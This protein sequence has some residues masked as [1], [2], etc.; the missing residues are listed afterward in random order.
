MYE[1]TRLVNVVEPGDEQVVAA[2][3]D[4]ISAAATATGART[5]LVSPTLPGARNG[6]DVVAHLQFDCEDQWRRTRA[7]FDLAT[8]SASVARINSVEYHGGNTRWAVD[9]G[10]RH[11][12]SHGTVYRTLLLRVDETATCAQI[13]EFEEALLRMPRY[14]GSIQAWQLSHVA[15]AHGDSR[16]T[17]VWEQ[18]FA[19]VDGLL[20][21]YMDHP[22]HWA[23][24]DPFF[25]PENPKC[26]VKDRV[27]HSFCLTEDHVVAPAEPARSV[28]S[29]L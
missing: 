8:S 26:I 22:F 6:G 15:V 19:D 12:A 21:E 16:W 24:V 13:D 5:T 7:D 9:S 17:H 14:I 29:A 28:D 25:D 3:A 20:R 23:S 11:P 2:V 18:E 4:Q 10:R 1:V 27:C